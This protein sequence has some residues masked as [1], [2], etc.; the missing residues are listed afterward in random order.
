MKIVYD[1]ESLEL[2]M[3]PG[4]S[5]LELCLENG[6]PL[7]HSCQGMASCGTCRLIV[8]EGVE[9]LPER[10]SLEQEMAQDRGFKPQ[11]RLA[12]QLIPQGDI[13][14]ILPPRKV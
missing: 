14:F 2:K 7:S 13:K 10:N 9:T 4:A 8:T 12:C 6:I 3:K 5:L 1:T 11:E